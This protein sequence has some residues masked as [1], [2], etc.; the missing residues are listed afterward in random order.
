MTICYFTASG[1]CLYVAK[2]IGGTLLSIPQLLNH[3]TITALVEKYNKNA[4]QIILRFETQEGFIAL[5]KSTNP[6]RIKSNINIFDFSLTVEE[7]NE[8][9]AMDTDA[10]SHDPDPAGVGEYLMNAFRVE[11]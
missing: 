3:P 8:I 10:T 2:R 9:R 7:M 1:N 5:P 6:E 4:G 11:D